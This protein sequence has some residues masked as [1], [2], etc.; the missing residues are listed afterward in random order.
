MFILFCF[1][2]EY[3]FRKERSRCN[4]DMFLAT[5]YR[6]ETLRAQKHAMECTHVAELMCAL[7]AERFR[8]A[9]TTAKIKDSNNIN[10]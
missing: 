2:I 4:R 6:M 3:I 5:N 1:L 10:C 7:C 9:K 8:C